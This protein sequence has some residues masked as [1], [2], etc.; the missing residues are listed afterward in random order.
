M[1]RLRPQPSL[2]SCRTSH[3]CMMTSLASCRRK[4]IELIA[5]CKWYPCGSTY[6]LATVFQLECLRICWPCLKWLTPSHLR[7]SQNSV[8]QSVSL[9]QL[10]AGSTL[11]MPSL[12]S[13]DA[14]ILLRKRP[15]LDSCKTYKAETLMK[16]QL[17]LCCV[18]RPFASGY[19][20]A[21]GPDQMSR[22]I[23]IPIMGLW[24]HF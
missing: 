10:L 1:I 7:H 11:P 13:L 2:S 3:R 14:Q 16:V 19:K 21:S 9:C 5:R 24:W 8:S 4:L 17:C 12:F 20:A 22:Y 6:L 15:R 23:T 18:S